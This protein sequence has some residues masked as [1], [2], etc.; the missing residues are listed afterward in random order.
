MGGRYLK[1]LAYKYLLTLILVLAAILDSSN[2]INIL[3]IL[4]TSVYILVIV[5]LPAMIKVGKENPDKYFIKPYEKVYP[6]HYFIVL[7]NA[8]CLAY[9][10]LYI[11]LILYILNVVVVTYLYYFKLKK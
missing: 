3:N 8:A 6:Q 4:L 5:L 10:N 7:I 2:F 9:I 11:P 1:D